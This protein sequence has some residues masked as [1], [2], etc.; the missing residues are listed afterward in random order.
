METE[1]I[2]LGNIVLN[3][4][5]LAG[6]ISAIVM[7]GISYG[8]TIDVARRQERWSQDKFQKKCN[9]YW[10]QTLI[11]EDLEGLKASAGKT[12]LNIFYRPGLYLACKYLSY[13]GH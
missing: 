5:A 1:L 3:S 6:G 4:T 11:Q 8:V 2:S 13:K 10:R 7:N 9:E 12:L